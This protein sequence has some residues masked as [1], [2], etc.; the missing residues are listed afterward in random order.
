MQHLGHPITIA[1]CRLK[2]AEIT[3]YRATPF[4]MAFQRMDDGTSLR[5]GIL[6][7]P[8]NKL[9]DWSQAMQEISV[10]KVLLFITKIKLIM[11]KNQI[12][13]LFCDHDEGIG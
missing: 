1:Q 9:K 3:Q 8:S 7:Y 2:V 13:G 12:S 4:S 11:D 6:S 5:E 10:P